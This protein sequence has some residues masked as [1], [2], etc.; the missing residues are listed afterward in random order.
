MLKR[1]GVRKSLGRDH[2][3]DERR[4]RDDVGFV[5]APMPMLTRGAGIFVLYQIA[6]LVEWI[7]INWVRVD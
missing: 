2:I 3:L 6:G 5:W 1:P 4:A 7:P